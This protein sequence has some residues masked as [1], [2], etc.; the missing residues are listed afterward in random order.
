M[1]LQHVNIKIFVDGDLAV[2]PAR[3]VDVFHEWVREQSLDEMLIDV[4]DYRHVPAGPGV[5]LIALEADY[6]IDQTAGRWGLRYNRKSAIE[7]TNHDRFRQ[8]L[9]GAINACHLL[10]AHFAADGPLTFSRDEF[11]LF[12]NDR[13]LAPNTPET[14]AS[15]KPEIESFVMDVFGHSDFA[16][17]HHSDVRSRFGVNIKLTKP[18][19]P[20][21]V[22]DALQRNA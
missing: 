15:C 1:E 13:A 17:T 11:E 3:F 16:L 7:G 10:E 14:Y 21:V 12:I 22:L 6:N 2:A 8:A 18:L 20:K 9:A 4:A 5:M 19:D